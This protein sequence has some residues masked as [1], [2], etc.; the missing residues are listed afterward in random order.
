[1]TANKGRDGLEVVTYAELSIRLHDVPRLR[2]EIHSSLHEATGG[3]K[4]L[5]LMNVP[6]GFPC[7]EIRADLRER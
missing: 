7:I 2:I 5:R 1:M 3:A 4:L 6:K